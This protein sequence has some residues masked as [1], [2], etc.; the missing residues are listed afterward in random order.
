MSNAHRRSSRE[1]RPPPIPFM[2]QCQPTGPPRPPETDEI[3][4]RL[5]R[6]T[7]ARVQASRTLVDAAR[8]TLTRTRSQV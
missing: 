2:A 6:D 7:E 1:R 3:A 4:A 8:E 5:K